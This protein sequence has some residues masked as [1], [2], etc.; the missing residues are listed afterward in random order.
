MQPKSTFLL[1]CI[2]TFVCARA[3]SAQ[4]SVSD[5]SGGATSLQQTL[6]RIQSGS[7]GGDGALPT[8]QD[9]SQMEQLVQSYVSSKRFMGSVLVALGHHVLLS[10]GYGFA[11]LEWNVPN[12]P[13]T[14]F[15][16]GSITKQFTAASILL[17]EQRGKLSVDD[18]V[19]KYIPNALAGWDEITIFNLLTHTSGIPDLTGF[20]DWQS[21]EPFP[22]TPE[23][24]VARFRDKPLDFQPG[25]KYSYSNS[26]YVLLGY[27]IEQ[28]SGETYEKFIQDNIFT[29]LGMS[30]SGYGSNSAI[31]LHRASGYSLS[32][33]ELVNANFVD[34]SV[35]FSSGG[36][37]STTED[38]LRW[39][40][41]LF[42]GKLLSAA[43]L[44]KMTTPFNGD[45][46][47]GLGVLTINGHKTIGHTGGIEG[48]NTALNYYPDDRLTIVVLANQN[49]KAPLEIE[50]NL[51]AIVYGE[52][53]VLPIGQ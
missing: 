25:E 45:Y 53:A 13:S 27:L 35:L 16:L 44:L 1:V 8:S 2:C 23:K 3:V 29:P 22:S 26:G 41:G 15:R 9:V 32:K 12:S 49:G 28:I 21:L 50:M 18:S 24:L 10:K 43:S 42:G 40:D 6:R 48:F 31:I 39:E 52:R 33:S 11:N 37:Y 20:L 46:A 38:L 47:F 36:I 30:D 17:L 7:G 4:T 19:K 51:A 14:K 5:N 34:T